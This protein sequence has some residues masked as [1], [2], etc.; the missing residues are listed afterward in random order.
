SIL[1]LKRHYWIVRDQVQTDG[2]HHYDLHFHFAAD[3]DP[4]IET[5]SGV[6]HVRESMNDRPGM[7]IFTFG[8]GGAWRR[9]EG[10]VSTCY[11]ARNPAAVLVFSTRGV[12]NQEF[13]TF[14]VPRAVQA[15]KTRVREVE[16]RGGRAFEV[17]DGPIQDVL[18]LGTGLPV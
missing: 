3:A 18:L 2:A 5:Q 16:A 12:G 9:A 6:T 15:H 1:F 10:W 4:V 7:Q 14:L 8:D 13:V 11:G 17:W